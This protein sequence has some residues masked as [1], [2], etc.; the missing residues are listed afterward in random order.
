M[1]KNKH[2]VNDYDNSERMWVANRRIRSIAS[3][4]CS[5]FSLVGPNLSIARVKCSS[6]SSHSLSCSGSNGTVSFL[7]NCCTNRIS[8]IRVTRIAYF[9]SNFPLILSYA[10]MNSFMVAI[11]GER[12]C[13][14]AK[15]PRHCPLP[16]SRSTR[17]HVDTI[18]ECAAACQISYRCSSHI[19]NLQ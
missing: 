6:S 14:I 7:L 1:W 16:E 10:I 17:Q 18:A 19:D 3:C 12:G 4:K 9:L 2:N 13:D 8:S 5:A 11:S 15:R